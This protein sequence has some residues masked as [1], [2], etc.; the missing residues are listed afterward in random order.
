MTELSIGYMHSGK[1]NE[2]VS[3]IA[4][5]LAVIE[6]R[7]REA[8]LRSGR[9]REDVT[10]IAVSKTKPV[11]MIEEAI[12]A[13][14]VDFGENKPQELRD[15]YEVLPKDLRWHMIGNLQRNK[16]KYVVPRAVMIH[17]VGS[18]ELACEIDK[19]AAKHDLVMPCLLEVNM[20][21]EESKGGIV[22]AQ[23]VEIL[24]R[25]ALLEHI[26]IRGLMT[27]APLTED[28]ESNRVYFRGLK[29]LAVDINAENIDNINICDLSMG[30]TGDFEVAIEEG[31]TFVRVGTGIFGERNYSV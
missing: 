26:Q 8:C 7:V 13:G 4:D 12:A 28:P 6:R 2:T 19:E 10:L 15:K 3:H 23:A 21:E 16:V 18:F 27:I 24:R 17:S 14:V 1:E 11:E 9:K 20:A 22:P 29:K 30:M 5:N 31:A 25:I